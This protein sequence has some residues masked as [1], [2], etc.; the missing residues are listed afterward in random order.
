MS[1]SA[2]SGKTP[3]LYPPAHDAG[4]VAAV[5]WEITRFVLRVRFLL[6]CVKV[7]EINRLL[8]NPGSLQLTEEGQERSLE[9]LVVIFTS[10]ISVC[11]RL[12]EV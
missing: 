8:E 3:V 12:Q 7:R 4:Q 9:V 2:L 1:S 5:G 11:E 6:R 10:Q